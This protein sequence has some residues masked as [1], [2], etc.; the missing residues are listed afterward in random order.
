MTDMIS[1]LVSSWPNWTRAKHM[2]NRES[3][4]P[5]GWRTATVP[6]ATKWGGFPRMSVR[7][8]VTR[9]TGNINVNSPPYTQRPS[10]KEI[11]CGLHSS[12]GDQTTRRLPPAAPWG[13]D[14][15]MPR[16]PSRT[17]NSDRGSLKQWNPTLLRGL[18]KG[19]PQSESLHF[20]GNLRSHEGA[21]VR[22]TRTFNTV[23][24]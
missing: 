22:E 3:S 20:S 2:V 12:C 14:L 15:R 10:D 9:P 4:C 8:G 18:E 7:N 21:T 19:K 17:G 24:P 6:V 1:F 13:S 11:F 5:L 23:S 16:S